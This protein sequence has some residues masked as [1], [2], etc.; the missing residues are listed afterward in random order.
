MKARLLVLVAA[1]AIGVASATVAQVPPRRAPPAHPDDLLRIHAQE[2][3]IDDTTL[4]SITAIAEG[5]RA[6]RDVLMLEMR[7]A[8][9]A[10]FALLS[11]SEPDR[12]AVMA[13]LEEIGRVETALR[14]LEIGGL[15]D[16]RAYLSPEQWS[17]LQTLEDDAGERMRPLHGP[18]PGMVP[19]LGPPSGPPGP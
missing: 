17:A 12:A 6:Q 2:L 4:A 11:A 19:P 7:A 15:L 3:G 18:P 13:Q 9:D 8:H 16:M 5:V 10:L 1:M 14:Q